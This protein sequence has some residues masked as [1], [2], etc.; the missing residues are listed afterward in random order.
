MRRPRRVAS[1]V[2]PGGGA[3]WDPLG[4]PPVLAGMAMA[5][6]SVSVVVNSLRLK[7]FRPSTPGKREAQAR[8]SVG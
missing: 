6:S 2:A 3:E 8:G 5:L 4:P 1:G 7:R